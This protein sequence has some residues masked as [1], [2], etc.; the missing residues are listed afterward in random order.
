[1]FQVLSHS[2]ALLL[3]VMLLMLGNGMQGTVLG[4]RAGLE[5]FSTLATS[6]VM[7]GY[8]AGFLA[9]SRAAPVLIRRV[10]HV[11]VFAALASLI[12]AA[13]ILFPVLTDPVSW[14]LLRLLLG[15][16]F[17][18]VYVTAESWLNHAATNETRGKAL[19]LY[20]VAQLVGLIVAQGL[21][22]RA[23]PG[24]FVAFI[25]PS[26]L[27]S[28]SFAPILLSAT[29]APTFAT[30]RS[31]RLGALLKISPLGLTGMAM[32]GGIYS[33]QFG[34]AA[35]FGTEAGLDLGQIALFIATMYGGGLVFQYPIG[36]IS[37]RMDRRHLIMA[38]AGLGA[39]AALGPVLLPGNYV[40]L[41]LAAALVGGAT[42]P[43]YALLI[44]H[45]N[46]FLAPEDMASASSGLMFV[47]GLGSTLGPLVTGLALTTLGPSGFFVYIAVLLAVL[48][49]YGAWRAT[50][51]PAPAVDETA[52][53]SPILPSAGPFVL[54][55]AQELY[56]EA[57]ETGSEATSAA[58]D[59]QHS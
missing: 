15:F 27:V 39:L 32:M 24:G 3:G 55:M 5:G 14:T 25:L 17:S 22:S 59:T 6:V 30:A 10:G 37:D 11:R 57:V 46:D 41:L 23:D 53:Y 34:M 52:H 29:P 54:D 35:V 28:I 16:S 47:N 33:A 45:T 48:A 12:S 44:A 56:A 36:W 1:M 21:V 13:L 20:M 7:A 18:V 50:R 42:N 31:M 9:G 49:G 8:F 58:E 26:V 51:R 19:S 2:W 43:L 38:V 40:A 4:V